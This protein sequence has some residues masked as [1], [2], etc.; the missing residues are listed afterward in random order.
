[1]SPQKM[2]IFNSFPD[3]AYHRSNPVVV[4]SITTAVFQN[5]HFVKHFDH[6]KEVGISQDVCY[7]SVMVDKCTTR[8]SCF[9]GIMYI[10]NYQIRFIF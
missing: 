3:T 6:M 5:T 7:F 10:N 1:M 9:S 8:V 4:H 2:V